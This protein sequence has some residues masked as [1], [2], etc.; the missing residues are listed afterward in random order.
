VTVL[1]LLPPGGATVS[2]GLVAGDSVLMW[3]RGWSVDFAGGVLKVVSGSVLSTLLSLIIDG[4]VS[5]W[6]SSVSKHNT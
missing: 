5:F 6:A 3:S 1:L 2:S 4:G